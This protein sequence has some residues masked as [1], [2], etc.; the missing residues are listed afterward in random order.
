MLDIPG[1]KS[2]RKVL[3][4][5]LDPGMIVVGGVK[6][7]NGLPLELASFP[8]LT[9]GLIHELTNKY[10]FLPHRE[11]IV[12]EANR[13]E[14]PSRMSIGFRTIEKRLK[15][16]ND[17]RDLVQKQ[18]DALVQSKGLIL[19]PNTPILST[20]YVNTEQLIKDSFNS[21]E[22][23]IPK[24]NLPSMFSHLSEKI[25]LADILSGK[26]KDKFRLP[27]DVEVML[28]LVVDYSYSMNTMDKLDMVIAAVNLFYS[29]IA[30]CMLNVKLQLYVF[31]ENCIQAKFPLSGKEIE[32]RG[33]HYGSFMKKILHHR[34]PDVINKVILFTDGEPNDKTDALMTGNKMKKLKVDYTQIIFDINEDRRIEYR[35]LSG[36][37]KTIDGFVP[38]PPP[39]IT[40]IRLNDADWQNR[41]AEI[42]EIFTEVAHACGGN[43]IIISIYELMSLISVE[44]YDYYLGN[45]TL[46][47]IPIVTPQFQEFKVQPKKN[48]T[49]QLKE[50]IQKKTVKP[51]E[52]KRI[53]RP[54]A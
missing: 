54:S 31:S 24:T 5:D 1:F 9:V 49:E 40:P 26:L 12:A 29:H 48:S 47:R 3:W 34:N 38:N 36:S 44:V 33:T 4:K 42:Y 53:E 13:G 2:L 50:E 30:E 39:G 6:V 16:F 23:K 25:T 41:K 8:A 18:R 28:H 15:Q 21:F 22:V 10:H 37:D 27:E 20:P 45:L 52:F 14:S 46:S 7:N 11:V 17:F 19:P 35:G 51:F 32:R 43:Q